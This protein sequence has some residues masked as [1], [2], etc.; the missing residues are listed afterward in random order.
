MKNNIRKAA[1]LSGY[2]LLIMALAAGFSYGFVLSS[3]PADSAEVAAHIKANDSLFTAGI[4]GWIVILICDILTSW[5]LY[6]F[7]RAEHARLASIMAGMRLIYTGVLGIAIAFLYAALQA[8]YTTDV[9]LPSV[10][11]QLFSNTWSIG[12]IIFGV[13][14]FLMGVLAAKHSVIP[15]IWSILLLFAG[16]CYVL[17]HMLNMA[18]AQFSDI[19]ETFESIL[20][21]PMAIGEL[22]FAV[23]L[24][25]KG[26]RKT[27]AALQPAS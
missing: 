10:Y 24:L 26:G 16:T 12:L 19:K 1:L 27:T 15:R 14:L 20:A 13:H 18:G 6:I 9:H 22:A 4:F 5:G 23:W 21:A 8:A 7:F 11:L 25:I 17:V 2:S 3:I